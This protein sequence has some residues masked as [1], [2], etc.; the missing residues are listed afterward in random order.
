MH[1]E[2]YDSA[3]N[4][5]IKG[6]NEFVA[7]DCD[8]YFWDSWGPPP[9]KESY[10]P[11]FTEEPTW[12][13]VYETVSK[14]TPVSPPFATLE[15]LS[16]YLAEHGDFW[17]QHEGNKGWGKEIADAFCRSGYAPSLMT[18]NGM[19]VESKDVPLALEVSR[20]KGGE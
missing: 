13:Q 4:D 10:R 9:E 14:G 6:F 19:V 5:W 11:A 1:D 8:K 3:A 12:Y 18:I 17:D 15:E 20:K 16:D 2:D 7:D